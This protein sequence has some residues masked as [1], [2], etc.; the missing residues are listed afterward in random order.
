M[1]DR[2]EGY[3]DLRHPCRP[4]R[5]RT[6]GAGGKGEISP[7]FGEASTRTCQGPGAGE[8]PPPGCPLVPI[9]ASPPLEETLSPTGGAPPRAKGVTTITSASRWH[10]EARLAPKCGLECG[11]ADTLALE[12]TDY[13]AFTDKKAGTRP[14]FLLFADFRAFPR[15]LDSTGLPAYHPSASVRPASSK[16]PAKVW[17]RVWAGGCGL[18]ITA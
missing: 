7:P 17:A 10:S 5:A 16:A 15:T 3:P 9:T 1:D 8:S 2:L 13:A 4:I 18:A 6:R 12:A 11:L 14:A